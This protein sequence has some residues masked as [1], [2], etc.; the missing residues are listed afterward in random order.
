VAH[1]LV[2]FAPLVI[3]EELKYP[4]QCCFHKAPAC[5]NQPGRFLTS[6]SRRDGQNPLGAPLLI[7]RYSYAERACNSSIK[8]KER[9]VLERTNNAKRE[10][11]QTP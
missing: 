5:L 11:S 2:R 9:L 4:R 8:A 7:F 3:D 1:G 10:L 6:Y